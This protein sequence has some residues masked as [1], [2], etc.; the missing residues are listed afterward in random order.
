MHTPTFIS[1]AIKGSNA[2]HVS[3]SH[4][5]L[6]M[7]TTIHMLLPMHFQVT[8]PPNDGYWTNL[9]TLHIFV[10]LRPTKRV[11]L[12]YLT[13]PTSHIHCNCSHLPTI[14][15][16]HMNCYLWMNCNCVGNAP[17]WI[18]SHYRE[19]YYNELYDGESFDHTFF[20]RLTCKSLESSSMVDGIAWRL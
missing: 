17:K 10:K 7:L 20:S 12:I 13:N 11:T 15:L 14:Y 2:N 8:H 19:L 4:F 9:K 18:F 3:E 1:Q 5:P 16:A 6:L